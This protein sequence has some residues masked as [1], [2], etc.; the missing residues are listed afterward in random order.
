MA[1]TACWM[2]RT[3]FSE[4]WHCA[5]R[6]GR[7][8]AAVVRERFLSFAM[9]VGIGFLLLVSLV[10]S[11]WLAALGRYFTTLLPMPAP[12]LQAVNA[13]LSFAVITVLFALLVAYLF[14]RVTE[15]NTATFRRW[16]RR[17]TKQRRMTEAAF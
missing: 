3:T 12:A 13:V 9:V 11:A 15:D 4:S 8:L 14:A 17:S 6:P 7:R 1:F 5:P 2:A 16:L 10:V